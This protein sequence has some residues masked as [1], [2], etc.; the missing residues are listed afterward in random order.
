LSNGTELQT[1]SRRTVG[2]VLPGA[3]SWAIIAFTVLGMLLFPSVWLTIATI[4]IAY[5]VFRL[6]V[7]SVYAFIGEWRIHEARQRDWTL[8][9]DVVGPFGFAPSDVRHVVVV[10]NYKEPEDILRR[11]LDGL[12]SQHRASERVI[13]VLGMEEREPDARAKG[14]ALAAEY[15]GRFL[16][17]IVTAHPA[18]IPGDE[19]GKSSNET[20]AARKALPRILDLG[21]SLDKATITSC[22]ADSVLDA[23]Y[24]AMIA[25][26]FAVEEDR[27]RTFWQAPIFFYNNIWQV[28]APIRLTTWLQHASQLSE[29]AMPRYNPLPIST[30]TLS[31]KLAEQCG[32]WDPGVIPEDWHSFLNCMFETGDDLQTVSVFLPTMGDA[33]DGDG[34]RDALV[35]RYEQLKRHSWGA[36]DVGYIYT[37]L[38]Q[39]K[40]SWTS[41]TAFRFGQVLHDHVMRT[42]AWVMLVSVYVLSAYYTQLHWYDLGWHAAIAQNLVVLRVLLTAG[43]TVMIGSIVFELWRCPPPDSVSRL[44]TA[45]E[46]VIMWFL[47]PVLGLYLGML[48][49]LSAQTRLMLGI[50]LGY[51]VTP[52]RFIGEP[53]KAAS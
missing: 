37:Q 13:V 44:K 47:L 3:L 21:V 25:S 33:T 9:E 31:L 14:E 34:M 53:Q 6:A 41:A 20:W 4:F 35:N 40:H 7:T 50:P 12:A 17:T 18:G 48:P 32:W 2:Y 15:A 39:R 5:F 19:P 27:H 26:S 11:T 24:F 1:E 23:S 52:K 22:D 49:A 36:E 46:L 38:V 45:T 43:G 10:P 16:G 28:P 42:A 8:D 29:L 51:K 30:Y